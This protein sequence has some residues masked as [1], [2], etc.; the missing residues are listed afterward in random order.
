MLLK[1]NLLLNRMIFAARQV[2]INLPLLKEYL[3]IAVDNG[4][5]SA[6]IDI[7]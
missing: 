4:N 1:V 6:N 2:A 7:Y 5:V 3:Y